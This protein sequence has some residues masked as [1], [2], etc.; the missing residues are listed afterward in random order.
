MKQWQA[1]KLI[2]Q[3]VDLL[4]RDWF[5][6]RH[7]GLTGDSIETL[8]ELSFSLT[9]TGNKTF[10]PL[11]GACLNLHPSDWFKKSKCQLLALIPGG[12]PA[13]LQTYLEPV[14]DELVAFGPGTAGKTDCSTK[15]Y[16][17]GY[18]LPFLSFFF[19]FSI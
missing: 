16:E 7:A 10:W 1:L 11:Y 15:T 4:A 14:V 8:A 13:N 9:F 3:V 5:V 6:G 19:E 2:E 17:A 12:K 18:H